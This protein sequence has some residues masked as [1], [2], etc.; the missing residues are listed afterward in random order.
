MCGIAGLR[1]SASAAELERRVDL[2]TTRLAHRGPDGSGHWID[3]DAGIALGHRRLAIVDLSAAGHQPMS[4]AGGQ[5]V[6]T[7]NGELYNTDEIRTALARA[8]VTFRG[9][10]DTE[11]LVNAIETWG[12]TK[13]LREIN[14]IFAFAVFDRKR[15][16]LT[17]VRDRAGVKPLFWSFNRGTFLFA[18]ELKAFTA[19]SDFDRQIDLGAVGSYLQYNYIRA[20]MTIYA[21]ARALE[22]G[23]MLTLPAANGP[24]SSEPH[25]ERYWDLASIVRDGAV[26]RRRDV[27]PRAVVDELD[28]L[29][30]DAVRRQLVSDVPIGA[31]LS[32]GVDS[33]TVVA[34]MQKASARP[35][36]TF[37]IGFEVEALNEAKYAKNVAAALGTEHSEHYVSDTEVLDGIPLLTTRT[38]QPHADAS[39]IPTF[40]LSRLTR[41]QV[42]VALSGDGG[43]E[44][45]YGYDRFEKASR[46]HEQLQ[47]VP[48]LA[49]KSGQKALSL[50]TGP[51]SRSMERSGSLH[52]MLWHGTNVL[53]YAAKD[54]RDSYLHFVTH[55]KAPQDIVPGATA[56]VALWEQ[57][58]T[59]SSDFKEVMM[60]FDTMTFLDGVLAKVDRASMGNSL[61]VRVPL[62]DHRLIEWAWKLPLSVKHRDNSMKWCLRQVLYKYVPQT[63]VDRPKAGFAA[64]MGQWLR[65]PLRD[66]A[67]AR[68][69]ERALMDRGLVNPVPI[70]RA[71]EAH[72]AGRVDASSTLWSVILLQDWLQNAELAAS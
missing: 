1:T 7:Y 55:W 40:L 2:M 63:L 60:Y 52:R 68:I 51:P 21:A 54:V 9:S 11:V 45:F 4:S 70:R 47:R 57:S 69:S 41:G 62:L 46:L 59:V 15:R 19:L 44:L 24:G 37:S 67:E 16:E 30:G 35:V 72:L 65:G 36:R 18:S 20:P 38:D 61:E 17:L 5:F 64:P 48:T 71:W 56:D 6:I 43:D 32:G 53:N 14:G 10:S 8:G 22:P 49:R 33:S 34:L 28:S 27:D 13:T 31:F 39:A 12:F 26:E 50:L 58:K 29:I 25:I 42:T 3:A 66:W 23:A